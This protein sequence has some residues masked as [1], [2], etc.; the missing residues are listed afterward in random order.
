MT[1]DGIDNAIADK[2]APLE[3]KLALPE[4]EIQAG[5][6]TNNVPPPSE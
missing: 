1:D 6:Y 3:D 2:L 4:Q 5:Q